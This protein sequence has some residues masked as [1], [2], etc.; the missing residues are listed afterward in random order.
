M[1]ETKSLFIAVLLVL[2][3]ILSVCFVKNIKLKSKVSAVK[4]VLDEL[5]THPDLFSDSEIFS[6]I[7]DEDLIQSFEKLAVEVSKDRETHRRFVSDVNHELRNPIA[8]ISGHVRLLQRWGKDDPQVLEEGLEAI[9]HEAKRMS[10]MVAETLDTIRLQGTFEGHKDD[11]CELESTIQTVMGNFRLLKDDFDFQYQSSV[12]S[13]VIGKVYKTHFEQALVIL[14]DNAVKYS[15]ETKSVKVSLSQVENDVCISVSNRGHLL[16]EAQI[17]HL[18]ERFYR[19]ETSLK[20]QN[21]Q[22]GAGIGLSILKQIADAYQLGIQVSSQKE[23]G[24]TFSLRV[25]Q[26][27]A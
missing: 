25:P 9:A 24:T 7:N 26:S 14:L 23:S 10:I 2:L 15:D 1:M 11:T 16:S 22:A 27:H 5:S 3:L 4:E 6:K 19:T 8:V 12:T 17:E 18:F 13:P 21:T 20:N